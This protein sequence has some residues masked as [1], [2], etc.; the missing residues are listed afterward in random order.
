[1]RPAFN[2]DWVDE[3]LAVGGRFPMEAAE[4]LAR[5]EGMGAIVD[6]RVETCDDEATLRVHGLEFLHLP[7]VDCCAIA[8]RMIDDGVEWVGTR[9]DT[10]TRV[11]I[12]CE[13]GVGR[14]ALLALC[15]LV[16]RG[17][18]PLDAMNRIKTARPVVS[19]APE[20]LEAFRTW[21]GRLDP[22]HRI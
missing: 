20:Q 8:P 16:G 6:L 10:G 22:V 3:R 13:H 2:F 5:R 11:L 9:L 14:S 12:H 17:V 15:V 7:T 18:A 21:A 19:P 4:Q 1:M